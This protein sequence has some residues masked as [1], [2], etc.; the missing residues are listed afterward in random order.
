MKK[1]AVA[2]FSF[3]LLLSAVG[4]MAKEK[5][6]NKSDKPSKAKNVEI[7]KKKVLSES[8]RKSFDENEGIA[9]GKPA[10]PSPTDPTAGGATGALGE[11][12]PFGGQR[13]AILVGL[14]NYPGKI[15]DLCV[16]DA[17]T[18]KDFPTAIDGLAQYCKDEDALNMKKAL[19]EKYG[20]SEEN[21]FLFSDADAKFDAIKERVDYLVGTEAFPAK[22]TADDELVFFFSG[23]SSTGNV[24]DESGA[25]DESLD[26]AMF[27][28]DQNYT[29]ADFLS[30]AYAPGDSSYVWDDQLKAWFANA[31]T[32]RILFAFDTCNAG[33]MNDLEADGR[34]LALSST[35]FQS[36][37]TYYLGGQQTDVNIFQESEGLFA[38]YFVKRAMIDELGDGS[39]PLNKRNVLKYDGKVAVEEAFGYAKPIIAVKQSSIL[40]DKFYNDLLLGY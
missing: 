7:S 11:P 2:I 25:N 9:K 10:K 14:A 32:K 40:N 13:Y 20:Y 1:T 22:L 39:N 18:G 37:Y 19:I 29:E 33:G 21:I 8:E 30:G 36:S 24:F 34:V 15:N 3:A 6:E 26:E 16:T 12:L 38:H 35:E 31:P 17:K 27:I 23:H 5:S 4:V 28:Y